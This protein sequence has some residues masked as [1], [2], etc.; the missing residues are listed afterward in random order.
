M[1]VK[2]FAAVL[3]PKF[4]V[5]FPDR[6][7]APEIVLPEHPIPQTKTPAP[8]GVTA[9]EAVFASSVM[10]GVLFCPAVIVNV[11]VCCERTWLPLS[12]VVTVSESLPGG[13]LIGIVHP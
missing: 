11:A 8:L 9:I 10:L 2:F 12:L 6:L 13:I 3:L 5:Q 7:L 1:T 4:A